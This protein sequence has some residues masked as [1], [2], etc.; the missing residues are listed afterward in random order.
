MV[1]G[2]RSTLFCVNKYVLDYLLNEGS[3]FLIKVPKIDTSKSIKQLKMKHKKESLQ[4]LSTKSE[5][6]FQSNI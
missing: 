6:D 1:N 2:I 3:E 5:Y 4:S